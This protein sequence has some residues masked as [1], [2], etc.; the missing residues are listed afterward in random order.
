MAR[1]L[2]S[3]ELREKLREQ[4]E[5]VRAMKKALEDQTRYE[6]A[7]TNADII[8]TIRAYWEALPD[9][10]RPDWSLMPEHISDMIKDKTYQR[11]GQSAA[12]SYLI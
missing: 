10:E 12:D 11:Q 3:E 2:S 9:V 8:R 6:E 4:E 7:R 5:R 1:R